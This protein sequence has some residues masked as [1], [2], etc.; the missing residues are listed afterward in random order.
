MEKKRLFE[1]LDEMNLDD[2]KENKSLV[3]VSNNFIS[4][5]KVKAGAKISMGV[6]ESVLFKLAAG[7]HTALLIIVD[8][9]EY[10]KR[11]P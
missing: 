1:V 7:T 4:G 8:Q 10:N 3:A 6:E 5:D 2:C 9:N 11:N